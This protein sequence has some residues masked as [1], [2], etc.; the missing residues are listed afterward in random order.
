MHTARP[1]FLAALAAMLA[2]VPPV[3]R[4]ADSRGSGVAPVAPP[5]TALRVHSVAAYLRD[6]TALARRATPASSPTS[7]GQVEL[8]TTTSIHPHTNMER[9][10]TDPV[11]GAS[12]KDDIA[13]DGA[14][15]R[16]TLVAG[17]GVE[18]LYYQEGRQAFGS[19]RTGARPGSGI[20]ALG[21]RERDELASGWR[22]A[23]TAVVRGRHVRLYEQDWVGT[24][25]GDGRVG[26][27]AYLAYVDPATLLV[28][29]QLILDR[30]HG[31]RKVTGGYDID[32]RLV[33]RAAAIA[34]HVFQFV[35]V[36][37]FHESH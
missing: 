34:H 37:G 19:D 6:L 12:R 18:F 15:V 24:L 35:N 23:G 22:T 8:V 31:Q 29:R 36:A 1:A 2:V 14:F 13:A 26:P 16:T 30:R 3:A 4:A 7:A 17:K 32:Y 25:P 5:R 21:R 11:T 33:P 27:G 20:A 28:Y 9:A 10:W